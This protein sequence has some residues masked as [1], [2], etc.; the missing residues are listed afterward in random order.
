MPRLL[1]IQ[2][3]NV[4]L[5]DIATVIELSAPTG[6]KLHECRKQFSRVRMLL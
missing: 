5:V 3:Q 4:V 6:Y 1:S 2:V